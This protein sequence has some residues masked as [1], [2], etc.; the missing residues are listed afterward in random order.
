MIFFAVHD[1]FGLIN[2]KFIEQ[3]FDG[4]GIWNLKSKLLIIFLDYMIQN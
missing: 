2:V 3:E 4:V 1:M